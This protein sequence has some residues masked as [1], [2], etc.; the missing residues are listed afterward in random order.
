MNLQQALDRF[1]G[2]LDSFVGSLLEQPA[3]AMVPVKKQK[4]HP[5]R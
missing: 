5:R 1:I 2:T 3:P 4:K